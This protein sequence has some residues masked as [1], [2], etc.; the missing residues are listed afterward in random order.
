[1]SCPKAQATRTEKIWSML[2]LKVPSTLP[3]IP[4]SG[5]NGGMF[6]SYKQLNNMTNK[7]LHKKCENGINKYLYNAQPEFA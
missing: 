2:S 5:T 7:L 6:R 3:G 1:M 4:K